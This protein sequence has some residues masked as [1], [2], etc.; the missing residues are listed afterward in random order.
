MHKLLVEQVRRRV[1]AHATTD[2]RAPA[3]VATPGPT[4]WARGGRA[5]GRPTGHPVVW[6]SWPV[7][8][9]SV[10]GGTAK[11][12]RESLPGMTGTA[13]CAVSVS[14]GPACERAAS[15]GYFVRYT[16]RA[17]LPRWRRRPIDRAWTLATRAVR[18]VL[19]LLFP[20]VTAGLVG[21]SAHHGS[22]GQPAGVFGFGRR[23]PGWILRYA[24][25]RRGPPGCVCGRDRRTTLSIIRVGGRCVLGL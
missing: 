16:S 6:S 10:A 25:V 14:A 9:R 18:G 23:S 15:F 21:V 22:A 8:I 19:S 17:G 1:R 2:G 20:T 13:A 11:Y 3:H 5:R 7:R 4:G 12:I 24:M